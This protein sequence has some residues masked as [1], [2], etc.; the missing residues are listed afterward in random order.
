[1]DRVEDAVARVVGVE[2][3]VDEAGREVALEGQ[4]L[5]QAGPAGE[6][7]EIEIGRELLGLLVEDVERPVEVVHE[8]AAAARFLPQE[9][10]PR[11]QTAREV[12]ARVRR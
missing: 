6:T 8:E 7:V 5:E 1:M 2:D 4:L 3:E 12:A 11:Q 10:H 9:I